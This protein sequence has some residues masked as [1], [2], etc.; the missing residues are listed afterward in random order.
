[1]KKLALINNIASNVSI[2]TIFRKT[3]LFLKIA[4]MD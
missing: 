3:I 1:M 2:T 4:V